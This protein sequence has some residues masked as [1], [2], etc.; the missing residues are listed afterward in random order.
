[1]SEAVNLDEIL[2]ARHSQVEMYSK[3]V[4][5]L[6]EIV[7]VLKK[8]QTVTDFSPNLQTKLTGIQRSFGGPERVPRG[9]RT[10]KHRRVRRTY[11]PEGAQ[12][13]RRVIGG[14]F[15]KDIEINLR[16]GVS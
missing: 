15:A 13:L 14:G 1:M 3:S 12:R 5:G 4:M 9:L 11:L 7:H 8:Y 6:D 2:A 10:V 16:H